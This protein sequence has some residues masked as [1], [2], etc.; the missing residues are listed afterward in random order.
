MSDLVK[1]ITD[2][3]FQQ[4]VATGVTLVDFWAPW[5]GPC[6]M[7]APIL[8]ELAGELQSQ[9]QIVKINVDE[10]PVVAGQFGVMS[11]PTLLLFKDGKKVDQKVG[12]Q[13]K[14]ALK[15]FIQQ[16]L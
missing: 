10:N 4:T 12:G 2:A 6:R 3:D 13:A 14:P 11:I 7:I 1:H 16:A 15:A 5:C 8:D 9:A